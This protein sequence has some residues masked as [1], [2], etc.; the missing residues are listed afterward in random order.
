MAGMDWKSEEKQ[1]SLRIRW[2]KITEVS[3]ERVNHSAQHLWCSF[4]QHSLTVNFLYVMLI[5][6]RKFA[7][8][9]FTE[10]SYNCCG[11]FAKI[12]DDLQYVIIV[13][14]ALFL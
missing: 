1:R 3:G 5:S 7:V 2:Q 14:Q 6:T 11:I 10:N 8:Q 12:A 9:K 4:L 13:K